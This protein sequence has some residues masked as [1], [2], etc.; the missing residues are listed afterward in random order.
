MNDYGDQYLRNS[1]NESSLDVFDG[2]LVSIRQPL[3]V[4]QIVIRSLEKEGNKGLLQYIKRCIQGG[5]TK[6]CPHGK[7]SQQQNVHGKIVRNYLF[8]QNNVQCKYFVDAIDSGPTSLISSTMKRVNLQYMGMFLAP[9]IQADF[10][11]VDITSMSHTP[12]LSR[13]LTW[14]GD[15][16]FIGYMPI[17]NRKMKNPWFNTDN[18]ANYKLRNFAGSIHSTYLTLACLNSYHYVKG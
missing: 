3:P 2:R 8:L 6:I 17:L 9:V 1:L 18:G 11:Q 15:F 14:L 12:I 4:F 13:Y 5:S 7:L 16:D 10:L